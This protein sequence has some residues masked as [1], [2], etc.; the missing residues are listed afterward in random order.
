MLGNGALGKAW[1]FITIHRGPHI[2]KRVGFLFFGFYQF[3]PSYFFIGVSLGDFPFYLISAFVAG[4]AR[5]E[6]GVC[7]ACQY[8]KQAEGEYNFMCHVSP[9][10]CVI[11][12]V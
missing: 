2:A 7:A 10:N 5:E 12:A 11:S 8:G 9:H 6:L 4:T 3:D 1:H